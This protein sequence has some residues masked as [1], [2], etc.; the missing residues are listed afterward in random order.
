MARAL[1]LTG[2]AGVGKTTLWEAAIEA[3]RSR[4]MRVLATRA[5]SAE[6]RMSFAALTDLLDGVDLSSLGSLPA[7]QRHALEVALLRAEPEERP[8]DPRAIAVGLLNALRALAAEER[9]AIAVDDI[10]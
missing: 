7:P 6:A 1:V 8:P 4:G 9:L 10:Q 2:E 3:A 5:S